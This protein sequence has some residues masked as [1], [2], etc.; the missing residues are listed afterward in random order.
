MGEPK[1][2][3]KIPFPAQSFLRSIEGLA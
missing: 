1:I 2:P 3:R